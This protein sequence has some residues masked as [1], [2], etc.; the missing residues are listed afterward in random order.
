MKHTNLNY[1]GTNCT[2]PNEYIPAPL[3]LEELPAE[4]QN[5]HEREAKPLINL[6]E[7]DDAFI[8]EVAAPVLK[9][10]DLW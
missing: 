10:D 6:A 1:P 7:M 4:L 9:S 8:I 2:Y 3:K 5:P